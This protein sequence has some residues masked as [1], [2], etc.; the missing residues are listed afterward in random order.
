[1]GHYLKNVLFIL[2]KSSRLYFDCFLFLRVAAASVVT[3]SAL[4]LS[5]M[6]LEASEY[7][8]TLFF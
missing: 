1:M 7:I 3:S 8:L 6:R 2:Q 5:L 4:L